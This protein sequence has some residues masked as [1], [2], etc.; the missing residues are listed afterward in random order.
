MHLDNT[1]ATYFQSHP[2]YERLSLQ[3]CVLQ[4]QIIHEEYLLGVILYKLK[5]TINYYLYKKTNHPDK[6]E[7]LA[8]FEEKLMSCLTSYNPSS[9]K[10]ITFYSHCIGNALKN[11]IKANPMNLYSLD[12]EYELGGGSDGATST[13]SMEAQLASNDMDI[14]NSDSHMLLE[15]LKDKLDDN[16][17]N[18]CRVILKENHK[19]TQLEI[20]KEI[21]L[22]LPAIKNIFIRLQK[23]FKAQ[24]VCLK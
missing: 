5:G 7:I 13:S 16:A 19:L 20:A 2:E 6:H 14:Q 23:V 15:Q 8:L 21:G 24:D 22:T 12:F 11:F 4:Y 17:Y 1:E 10:F 3:N 18:V 9:S